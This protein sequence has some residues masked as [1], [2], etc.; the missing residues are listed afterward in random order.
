MFISP[1]TLIA[2]EDM[3]VIA[4]TV[5]F[6]FALLVGAGGIFIAAKVVL[7]VGN[8]MYAVI[9]ALIGGLFLIMGV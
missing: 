4:Q 2:A 3:S 5:W 1:I 6:L 7:N 8:F 9:S